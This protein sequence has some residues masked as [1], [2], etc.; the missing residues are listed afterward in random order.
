MIRVL[1]A[2]TSTHI[3]NRIGEPCANPYLAIASQLFAGLDGLVGEPQAAT[4]EGSRQ[5]LPT[6]LR[7]ALDAFR[8]SGRARELLGQPLL[9][10]LAKL[11]ESEASRFEAWCADVR[12]A[13]GEVTEWE[14]REYFGV[15]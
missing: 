14:Q 7:E 5:E 15:F 4:P 11:K 9:S 1:G 3:E 13:T 8:N 6:S 10:C 2:G 12:P